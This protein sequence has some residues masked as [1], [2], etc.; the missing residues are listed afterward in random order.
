MMMMTVTQMETNKRGGRK[1][2]S[3]HYIPPPA[4]FI[5]VCVCVCYIASL[6]SFVIG[7]LENGL[8]YGWLC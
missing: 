4:H 8:A 7:F 1:I 5:S 6:G 2:S 3:L